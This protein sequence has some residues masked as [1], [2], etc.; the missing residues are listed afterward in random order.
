MKRKFFIVRYKTSKRA[1]GTRTLEVLASTAE[2]A[3]V[4]AETHL[5]FTN[6]TQVI[7]E[8]REATETEIEKINNGEA[9]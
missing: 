9:I 2:Y 5:I 6:S 3:R 4:Y 8:V 7:L 1:A